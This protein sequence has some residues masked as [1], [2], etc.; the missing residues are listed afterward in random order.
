MCEARHNRVKPL[1]NEELPLRRQKMI[2]R[3]DCVPIEIAVKSAISI[4]FNATTNMAQGQQK[5]DKFEGI[6]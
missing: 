3:S 2:H 1:S 4:I 6:T 5:V